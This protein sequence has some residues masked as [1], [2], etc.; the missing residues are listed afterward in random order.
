VPKAKKANHS[1]LKMTFEKERSKIKMIFE[2]CPMLSG[3]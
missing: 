1:N 2:E 3:A